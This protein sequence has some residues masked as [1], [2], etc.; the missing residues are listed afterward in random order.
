MARQSLVTMVADAVL[1]EIVS[2]TLPPGSELPP[3]AELA[4]RFD[5]SRV[6]MREALKHLQ[7][8]GVLDVRRGKR[9]VVNPP[10]LWTDLESV[11]RATV[12]ETDSGRTSLQLIEVRRMIETGAAALSAER[13]SERDL[14]EL[15]GFLATMRAAH[16][17]NDVEV[18]VEADIAF[19]DVILRSADNLF[20]GVLFAPL[21]KV[22]REARTQ[23]SR[24]PQIQENAI[25]KH[26][27][28]LDAIRSGDPDA[29]ARAM[30]D[31]MQ[32]TSDDL[33]GL[34]LPAAE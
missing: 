34:V 24:L 27:G 32:Q 21:A 3:E 28:V 14:K 5:V 15:D 13:R 18:F 1:D 6:T 4:E 12:H 2:G 9:G 33:R 17:R 7:G 26:Q 22:M 23:T 8:R 20:I 25:A 31:H 10:S 30:A 11:L 19:H 29:A 16:E